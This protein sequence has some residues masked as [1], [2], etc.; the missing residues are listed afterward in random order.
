MA[1]HSS[2]S[3]SRIFWGEAVRSSPVP[4]VA[5]SRHWEASRLTNLWVATAP[6]LSCLSTK[7][8]QDLALLSRCLSFNDSAAVR[9]SWDILSNEY[10]SRPG[11]WVSMNWSFSVHSRPI[12]RMI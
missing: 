2:K 8:C 5:V 9:A 10:V 11:M 7:A 12:F 4:T 1:R 3:C 6:D